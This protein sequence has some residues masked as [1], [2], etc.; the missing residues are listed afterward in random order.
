MGEYNEM[1]ERLFLMKSTGLSW[2][3]VG[4][5]DDIEI[6]MLKLFVGI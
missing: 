6:E 1:Q 2:Q 4:Q 5:M 3:D